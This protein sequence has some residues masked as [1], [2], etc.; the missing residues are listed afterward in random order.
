MMK[1]F[2]FALFNLLSTSILLHSQIKDSTKVS[3]NDTVIVTPPKPTFRPLAVFPEMARE[4]SLEAT[5]YIKIALGKDGKPYKTVISKREPEFVFLFDDEVRRAAMKWE[6]SPALT[7]KGDS[8]GVWVSIPFKF[9]L[10]DFEPPT[11]LKQPPPEYPSDALEMGL[12][13]WV[14][15]AVLVDKHGRREGKVIIVSRE[16]AST[17]VFDDAAIEVAENT[18]FSPGRIKGLE[19]NG[20]IF[21]KV[22]FKLSPK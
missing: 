15:L 12:E 5:I 18:E 19:T 22:E 1:Y 6:F 2:I 11:I 21:M 14:G 16:P 13:G 17:K 8:I 4:A 10:N 3:D 9:K 20:W 7:N